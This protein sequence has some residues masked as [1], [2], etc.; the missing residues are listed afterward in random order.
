MRCLAR[1]TLCVFNMKHSKDLLKLPDHIAL[2][3]LP[4]LVTASYVF[5]I[6]DA[7]AIYEPQSKKKRV[8]LRAGLF[9]L[10]RAILKADLVYKIK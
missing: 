2:K 10:E 6:V 8:L 3:F 7:G 5:I 1:F 9:I 4:Q